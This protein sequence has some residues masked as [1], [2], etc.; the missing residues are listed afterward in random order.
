MDADRLFDQALDL[1]PGDRDRWL[2][3]ACAGNPELRAKVQSLLRADAAAT[4]FLELDAIRLTERV[5]VDLL[6]EELADRYRMDRELGRGGMAT[7]YLARDLKHDRLV[8]LKVLRRDLLTPLAAQRFEREIRFAARLQHPHILTVL[9]SGAAGQRGGAG[10]PD[11]GAEM[12]WFTMPYVEGE[13]LRQR[14]RRERRLPVEDAVR[15][16]RD[17][18]HALDYAHRQGLV[19]RDIKPENILLNREG[20]PLVADFGIA[21]TLDLGAA[22]GGDRLTRTGAVL[23]TPAYMSLEQAD[24]REVDGRTDIYSLGVVLYEM[25]AGERPF[26]GRSVYTIVVQQL[27]TK[28]MSLAER[29]VAISPALE[30]A[31]MRMLARG[32]AERYATAGEVATALEAPPSGGVVATPTLRPSPEEIV[33]PSRCSP[34]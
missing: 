11:G 14:V 18:A 1:S 15:I 17:V 8:A 29:G 19:H 12:L 7:V 27:T 21:R 2:D 6:Q 3:Q 13:S 4:R 32:P 34:S 30:S 20:D 28:P 31:V 10:A 24:G 33:A 16:A 9:D 23:G 26:S 22:A 25:L 5:A